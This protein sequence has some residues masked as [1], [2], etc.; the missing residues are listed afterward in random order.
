MAYGDPCGLCCYNVGCRPNRLHRRAWI[1][2]RIPRD[3]LGTDEDQKT[4]NRHHCLRG[5]NGAEREKSNKKNI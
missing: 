2:V 3:F 5:G 4:C 1:V